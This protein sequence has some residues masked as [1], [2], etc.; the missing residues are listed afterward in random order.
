[1]LR[2]STQAWLNAKQAFND[3]V[4]ENQLIRNCFPRNVMNHIKQSAAYSILH[5]R[6]YVALFNYDY[7]ILC[8]FP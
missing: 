5:C 6:R 4:A 7:L 1:M 3:V 8:Y 2:P